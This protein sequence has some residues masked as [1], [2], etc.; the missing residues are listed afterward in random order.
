[1][2]AVIQP[3]SWQGRRRALPLHPSRCGALSALSLIRPSPVSPVDPSQRMAAAPP[4][5]CSSPSRYAACQGAGNR[6]VP[7]AH[8]SVSRKTAYC[9]ACSSCNL[10]FTV[11]GKGYRDGEHRA[12]LKGGFNAACGPH[13]TGNKGGQRS[14]F[15]HGGSATSRSHRPA[16]VLALNSAWE[17]RRA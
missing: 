10:P 3:L 1:M 16:T 7:S 4:R 15:F 12:A 17:T 11:A 8:F 6:L 14:R 2:S 13:R 9:N 5:P